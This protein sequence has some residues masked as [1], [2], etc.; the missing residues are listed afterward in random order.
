MGM[1]LT[2]D[3]P[4]R[5]GLDGRDR[6]KLRAAIRQATNTRHLR[7]LQAVLLLAM[8]Q[9][10][11]TIC[12]MTALSRQSLY[13]ALH[14][15]ARQHAPADLA[16]LPRSGR[17]PAAASITAEQILAALQLDPRS[18]GY[19]ATTWTVGPLAGYLSQRHG[20][21]IRPRTLRRRMHVLGLRWKRPR[22][23]YHLRDPHAAQKKGALCGV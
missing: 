8:G 20:Q 16:D 5:W 17:P 7:R 14:R 1:S 4:G 18:V 23:V 21:L 11:D 3:V 15:Y 9:P 12:S 6:R 19:N 22:Y 10:M 2:N 13:N